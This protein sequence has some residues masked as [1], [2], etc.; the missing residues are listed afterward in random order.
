MRR[1]AADRAIRSR[2]AAS[3][4]PAAPS[5]IASMS[6][7]TPRRHPGSW[8]RSARATLAGPVWSSATLSG[9]ASR[10][11]GDARA[12]R[13]SAIPAIDLMTRPPDRLGSTPAEHVFSM[14][15]A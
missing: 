14:T 12:A 2:P 1:T 3:H 13:I 11:S 6:A 15:L 10:S 9:S 7:R 4:P 8:G 5:P